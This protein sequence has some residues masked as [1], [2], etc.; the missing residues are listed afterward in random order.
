MLERHTLSSRRKTAAAFASRVLISTTTS[1]SLDILGF[2]Q[3]EITLLAGYVDQI[4]L[5]KPCRPKC[6]EKIP[7]MEFSIEKKIMAR[8]GIHCSQITTI[9]QVGLLNAKQCMPIKIVKFLRLCFNA[10]LRLYVQQIIK[11]T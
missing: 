11:T 8:P 3:R 9:R 7:D 6:G 5:C 2:R 10:V 1:P 4:M